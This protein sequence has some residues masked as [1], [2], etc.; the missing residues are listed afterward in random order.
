MLEDSVEF[1]GELNLPK[2]KDYYK[3]SSCLQLH[4]K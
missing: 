1:S 4:M 2:V 3:V